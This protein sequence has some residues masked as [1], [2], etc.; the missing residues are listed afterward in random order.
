MSFAEVS[1]R[2]T[3]VLTIQSFNQLKVTIMRT[4]SLL[5]LFFLTCA[6]TFSL[7][8][9][10]WE[11]LYAPGQANDFI[12][13]PDGGFLL[14]GSYDGLNIGQKSRITKTDAE[15]DV[16]WTRQYPVED[17][18]ESYTGVTL[19]D[20]QNIVAIGNF[21]DYYTPSNPE[22][23]AVFV[24]KLDAQGNLVKQVVINPTPTLNTGYYASDI[25]RTAA[26]T[27]W[28]AV[29]VGAITRLYAYDSDLEPL[30]SVNMPGQVNQ[31][32]ALPDGTVLMC[33]QKNGSMYLCKTDA[34]AAVLWE[35]TYET[36][37]A[38]MTLTQ[39][40][41][42]V[43][44]TPGRI[45]KVDPAG[46]ILWSKNSISQFAQYAAWITEDQDGNLLVM[47]SYNANFTLVFSLGKFDVDGN[48]LWQKTP[49]QSLQGAQSNA[50]PLI[51][52]A[53]GYALA[54]DR[55]GKSMLMVTDTA[56][57]LYRSWIAGSMYHDLNDDCSKDADEKALQYFT[58][59][60]TDVHG[61]VW[62]EPIQ[63]GQYAMQ[64]PPGSYEIALNRRSYDPENW[65]SCPSQTAVI[66]PATDTAH[67]APLGTKSLS[68]CP[69]P[70]IQ[71]GIAK[72]RQCVDN[73]YNLTFSN[74][75]TQKATDVKIEVDLSEL[76]TY[77]GSSLPL[78][79][80]N[81]QKLT[82]AVGDLDI[83]EVRTATLTAFCTCDPSL[84]TSACT[85]LRI[86]PDTCYPVLADWDH[87]IIRIQAAYDAND[88]SFTLQ[89]V[90]VGAMQTAKNYQL[91]SYCI[92]V[93]ET[94]TFQL[95][96]GASQTITRSNNALA[97]LFEA[98]NAGNQ[99][100]I[101]GNAVALWRCQGLPLQE[102]WWHTQTGS[103]FYNL[104]CEEVRNSF[105]PNDITVRPRGE[106]DSHFI[107][108][109]EPALQYKIRFQNTGND[110]AYVVSLRD[111]L[112]AELE[113][114]SVIPGPSS[115]AYTFD[116]QHNVI[117]FL[118]K[119]INLPDSS[120]NVDAS[121]GYVI[122]TVK[123]KPSLPNGTRI[124][125]RAA[126]YFDFNTP[127]ITNTAV[128]TIHEPLMVA[129]EWPAANDLKIKVMPNPAVDFAVFQFD[130]PVEGQFYLLDAAG[131][132]VR[133][134]SLSG[135]DFRLDCQTLTPGVYFF[136]MMLQGQ[137]PAQG[138][139]IVT[140]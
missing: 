41:N 119:D 101:P 124:E 87:S 16:E 133:Q 38:C 80:K 106:G 85:T 61:T 136:Q 26:G 78:L 122:F 36:G 70:M 43:L 15:G 35:K 139:L 33:G 4:R 1:Q 24:H 127:V 14:A 111:T 134:A 60:A 30:W 88:V 73:T 130:S 90:G 94:G 8:A 48:L 6:T 104:N 3:F 18:I 44:A 86:T 42:I 28:I 21:L 51:T 53:G 82:F 108:A 40:G 47:G 63:Q 89:N 22:H 65:E 52:A 115:H 29:K 140:R 135:A 95:D 64:V 76:L 129:V 138:K 11:R 100:Y 46:D 92:S 79:A 72:M 10:N 13:T 120:S 126:I 113:V 68:D 2:R 109:N 121:Q 75:G 131:R 91:R 31:M 97:Y 110:T 128:N 50:K 114:T 23:F 67:I 56:F 77:V 20:P 57:D 66:T 62:S 99:P 55:S 12:Q 81:G 39:D 118:F 105:D 96:A 117:K 45:I 37:V 58:V 7:R 34:A 116:I 17:T 54:G 59:S 19:L 9:Q 123:M 69:R 32:I 102:A 98:E 49:H 25:V 137:P 112:P 132:S 71:S 27:L 83:D 103:P 93:L 74:F 125:N 5:F 84:G 107:L